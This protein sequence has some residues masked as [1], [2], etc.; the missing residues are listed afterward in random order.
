MRAIQCSLFSAICNKT[1]VF[2]LFPIHSTTTTTFLCNDEDADDDE[3]D[4]YDADK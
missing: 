1:S 2:P 4:E 3:A